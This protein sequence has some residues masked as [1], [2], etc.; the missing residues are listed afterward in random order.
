MQKLNVN[1]W[2]KCNGIAKNIIAKSF[3]MNTAEKIFINLL[4]YPFMRY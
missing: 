2:I 4:R 3:S 1:E